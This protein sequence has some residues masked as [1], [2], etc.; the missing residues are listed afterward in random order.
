MSGKDSTLIAIRFGPVT[1]WAIPAASRSLLDRV[2]CTRIARG[3]LPSTV[4]CSSLTSGSARIAAARGSADM[5]GISSF[6][7]ISDITTT[8]T[9]S[10]PGESAVSSASPCSGGKLTGVTL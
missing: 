5:A 6:A 4:S 9:G 1:S 10:P 2:P 7:T 3:C 8:R